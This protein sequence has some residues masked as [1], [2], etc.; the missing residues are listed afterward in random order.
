[1]RIFNLPS[2]TDEQRIEKQAAEQDHDE[3]VLAFCMDVARQ[4]VKRVTM[5]PKDRASD[6]VEGYAETLSV[7]LRH[8]RISE[9][10]DGAR[11]RRKATQRIVVEAADRFWFSQGTKEIPPALP[12]LVRSH[13]ALA[14][15]GGEELVDLFN[16]TPFVFHEFGSVHR[17]EFAVEQCT[18]AWKQGVEQIAFERMKGTPSDQLTDDEKL[19]MAM[20]PPWQANGVTE[21][22]RRLTKS[23]GGDRE[24][25]ASVA[26]VDA[27]RS[28]VQYPRVKE[29]S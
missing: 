28:L 26:W 27:C 13:Y 18:I 11:D 12:L 21:F 4:I 14:F 7:F 25:L 8:L 9:E 19:V 10:F 23:A 5:V 24:W 15:P 2:M 29:M 22:W 3:A 1:M 6:I 20:G 17:F 16:L